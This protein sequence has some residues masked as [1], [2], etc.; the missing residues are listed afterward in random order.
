MAQSVQNHIKEN[1]LQKLK[2]IFKSTLVFI[3]SLKDE[4]PI[5]NFRQ[6]SVQ[7][8]THLQFSHATDIL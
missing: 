3:V 4:D 6:H 8:F 5:S 2:A 1:A 7:F